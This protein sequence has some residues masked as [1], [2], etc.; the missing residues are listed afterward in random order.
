MIT[1]KDC[2][3]ITINSLFVGLKNN[4]LSIKELYNLL[5]VNLD[6][7]DCDEQVLVD[8]SVNDQ[9]QVSVLEILSNVAEINE[10]QGIRTWQFAHLLAIEQS[11]LSIHEKLKK[12]ELQWSGFEY[13]EQWRD[14]IYY[15]PNEKVN[16]EE[17]LYLNFLNF[18]NK[19]KIFF[20]EVDPIL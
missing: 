6:K 8:I 9:D 19:E 13:P 12:I 11:S 2:L 17:G 20:T 15:L 14:F 5:N 7:L 1:V 4:W 18:L 10:S 16:T 3:P